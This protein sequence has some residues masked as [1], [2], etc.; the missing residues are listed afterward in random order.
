MKQKI[1][2]VKRFMSVVVATVMVFATVAGIGNFFPN[3]KSEAAT[4]QTLYICDIKSAD[5]CSSCPAYAKKT[6]TGRLL[7]DHQQDRIPSGDLKR[8]FYEI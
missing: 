6:R 5:G 3:I 7:K 1:R 4:R 8:S 2:F